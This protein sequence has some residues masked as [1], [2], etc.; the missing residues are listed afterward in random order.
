MKKSTKSHPD[1]TN[2]S[3][4]F[5]N[6]PKFN[7]TFYPFSKV[8]INMPL[9]QQEF[10]RP[11]H[12]SFFLFTRSFLLLPFL[13]VC[14]K[15]VAHS[16]SDLQYRKRRLMGVFP[17]DAVP[18]RGNLLAIKSVPAWTK[19]HFNLR[20]CNSYDCLNEFF[21]MLISENS[22]IKDRLEKFQTN[23]WTVGD[24]KLVVELYLQ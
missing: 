4:I 21:F 24:F 23:Y 13:V 15:W 6:C 16:C 2:G 19:P 18:W 1:C 12:G 14:L 11:Y 3:V 17:H 20:G 7:W 10:Q 22:T 9:P 5:R 8:C